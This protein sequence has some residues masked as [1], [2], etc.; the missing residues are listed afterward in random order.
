MAVVL[1]WLTAVTGIFRTSIPE[2]QPSHAKLHL[3]SPHTPRLLSHVPRLNNQSTANIANRVLFITSVLGAVWAI[4]TL[5]RRKSTRRS[6]F[7]VS[8]I[9][10]CFAGALIAGVYELRHIANADCANFSRSQDFYITLTSTGVSGSSPFA[11]T[12]N[13]TCAMLK[14]SFAFG[15]MNII[16]F[17]STAFLLLFM[18]RGEEKEVVVKETYRR[19]SHD[20]RYV[21]P[22]LVFL[23]L[24]WQLIHVFCKPDAAIPAAAPVTTAVRATADDST[25][26]ESAVYPSKPNS[27]P[28]WFS[29]GRVRISNSDCQE[30]IPNI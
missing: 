29:Q 9:D 26:F 16:F 13:K 22:T 23:S 17:V 20:S 7:F 30:F 4:A 15:I 10:L 25:T 6:A 19:R 28:S 18:R 12:V 27:S 1:S 14:A 11:F 3:V 21:T 2:G 8:F 24:S 5:F